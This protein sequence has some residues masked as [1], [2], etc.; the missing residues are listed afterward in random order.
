MIEKNFITTKINMCAS[1]PVRLLMKVCT[2]DFVYAQR[3]AKFLSFF[4]GK[5]ILITFKNDKTI[6]MLSIK[7]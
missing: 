6:G 3:A 5:K 2:R 1:I 4:F 7:A